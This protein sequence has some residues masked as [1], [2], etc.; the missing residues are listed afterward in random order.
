MS[1]WMGW[2]VGMG[3]AGR[4]RRMGRRVGG[5]EEAGRR[6]RWC[7]RTLAH[8]DVGGRRWDGD[9]GRSEGGLGDG[10][11]DFRGISVDFRGISGT[12][13]GFERDLSE[14][15]NVELR[16]GYGWMDVLSVFCTVLR[17]K[18]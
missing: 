1:G 14:W 9:G 11:G 15:L 5:R 13:A 2:D 18:C 7:L 17:K 12:D 16:V 4:E 8:F 6:P 3:E 10:N